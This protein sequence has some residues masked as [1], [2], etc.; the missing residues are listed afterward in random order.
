MELVLTSATRGLSYD[1]HSSYDGLTTMNSTQPMLVDDFIETAPPA[2]AVFGFRPNRPPQPADWMQFR[3]VIVDLYMREDKTLPQV[4]QHM[5]SAYNFHAS[6]AA[7][8]PPEKNFLTSW[9]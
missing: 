2:V 6:Y 8:P 7:F 5:A 3:D 4:R 1:T 9:K